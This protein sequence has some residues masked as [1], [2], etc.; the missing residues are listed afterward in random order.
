MQIEILAAPHVP[1]DSHST[2]TVVTSHDKHEG[3]VIETVAEGASA[4]SMQGDEAHSYNSADIGSNEGS[5]SVDPVAQD[6][7]SRL[8]TDVPVGDNVSQAN[9]TVPRTGATRSINRINII[10]DPFILAILPSP[11][12]DFGQEGEDH[13]Q[14]PT[15]TE[16]YRGDPDQTPGPSA[17]EEASMVA[18]DVDA[19]VLPSRTP[20][21]VPSATGAALSTDAEGTALTMPAQPIQRSLAAIQDDLKDSVKLPREVLAQP[22]GPPHNVPSATSPAS[23]EHWQQLMARYDQID[24][25]IAAARVAAGEAIEEI[26]EGFMAVMK[27]FRKLAAVLGEPRDTKRNGEQSDRNRA[28]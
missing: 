9:H 19:V 3:V 18:M 10:D 4:Q 13:P 22:D 17:T 6:M 16:V 1:A 25:D 8:L 7:Q 2:D 23:R 20:M 21:T 15:E 14:S 12:R 27:G 24:G 28:A 26:T 5:M 11:T